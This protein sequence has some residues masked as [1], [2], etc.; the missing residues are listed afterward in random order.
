MK[1]RSFL[2]ALPL[3]IAAANAATR[4]QP[5]LTS[6]DKPLRFGTDGRF[7]ILAISDLHFGPEKDPY[8]VALTEDMIARERPDLVIANGDNV[9]GDDS[10]T[11]SQLEDAVNQVAQAME[12]AGVPWA[13]TLGNHDR[14]HFEHTGLADEAFFA[15]FEQKPH[16]L[17]RG[18]QRGITG[19]GNTNLLIWS[20]DGTRPQA[21]LWL[22]DSGRTLPKDKW[23]K[24][25]WIHH[26]QIAWYLNT[27]Q[28]LEKQYGKLPALMFHH[29]PLREFH[30]LSATQKIIGNRNENESASTV[31]SG[32]FAAILERGDV[33]GI[34]CGH[35]HQNNYIG[36]YRNVA[37]GFVGVTGVLNA[38]PFLKENDPANAR[39]RGGR[40]FELHADQPGRFKTWIRSRDGSV[41]WET[42]NDTL[43]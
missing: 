11:I 10:K 18:W 26:D 23:L 34:F 21:N 6:S 35:D 15:L 32:L 38:Y 12:K 4:S 43:A 39:L 3:T 7:K 42:W 30:D 31:N 22:V 16:N 25:E 20:S 1:R 5:V 37:L 41:N 29:I 27:S 17:N 8:A 9:M 14:E 24:Y 36:R 19:T 40:V 33:M 28:A 13:V 2:A